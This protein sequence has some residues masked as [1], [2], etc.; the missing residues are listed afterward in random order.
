MRGIFESLIVFGIMTGLLLPARLLF[1][2]FISDD[3]LG[4]FGVITAISLSIIILAKK[5]KLG[6]FGP[7]L[8]RQIYKFQKGKRGI[9]VFGESVFL[10]LVLGTMIVAI[11]QGSSIHSEYMLQ[12]SQNMSMIDSPEQVLEMTNEMTPTDWIVGFLLAPSALLTEFPKMSAAI[13]SIDQSLDGWLMHFYTVGFV[14][15]LELLGI[16]I[17]YRVSFKRKI[18]SATNQLYAK[19]AI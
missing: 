15:Y 4:S 17:F 10:L 18:S 8:E 14:E 5:K 11:D 19:A 9:A 2:E 7:M 16:L 12:N 6:I 13:A 3:W 1:V